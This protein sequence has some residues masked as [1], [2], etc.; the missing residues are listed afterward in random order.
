MIVP[1]F[2]ATVAAMIEWQAMEP[3]HFVLL[4][5]PTGA[6]PVA[7][8]DRFVHTDF[9]SE[10]ALGPVRLRAF[11]ARH[12]SDA[13]VVQSCSAASVVLGGSTAGVARV[14][15]TSSADE[16]DGV[17]GEYGL[18]SMQPGPAERTVTVRLATDTFGTVALYYAVGATGRVGAASCRSALRMLGFGRTQIRRV[19]PSTEVTIRLSSSALQ[20]VGGTDARPQVRLRRRVPPALA[21][22][23]ELPAKGWADAADAAEP[24]WH[25]LYDS[26]H[27]RVANRREGGGFLALSGG[28]S[29]GATQ[30]AMLEAVHRRAPSASRFCEAR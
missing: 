18:V 15:A 25:A 14:G 2:V 17:E 27:R 6:W 10:A 22:T 7:A 11:L 30:L 20:P 29:A 21:G 23:P 5:H 28:V 26:F 1:P 16:I 13:A 19:P 12:S 9:S 3:R 24:L 8:F 4:S